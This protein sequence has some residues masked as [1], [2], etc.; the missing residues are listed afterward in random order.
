MRPTIVYRPRWKGAIEGYTVNTVRKNFS[1]LSANYEFEDLMQEA[2][3]KFLKCERKYAGVVNNDRWFMALYKRALQH[4]IVSLI[5]RSREYSFIE[6][7]SPHT[8]PESS[9]SEGVFEVIRKL[10][11]ELAMIVWTMSSPTEISR[12]LLAIERPI[13][14]SKA[15]QLKNYLT[16]A[17]AL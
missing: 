8:M 11:H 2:Y 13:R 6:Y 17:G 5:R 1:Q 7:H 10:P 14:G 15:R 4:R 12:G 3:I 16:H 9:A